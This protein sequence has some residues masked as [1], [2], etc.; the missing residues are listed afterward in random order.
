M[1]IYRITV[2]KESN[3]EVVATWITDEYIENITN[4]ITQGLA[5]YDTIAE[6]Y[7]ACDPDEDLE[8]EVDLEDSIDDRYDRG[9]S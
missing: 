1:E 6:Y 8:M 5:T 9:E 4:A 7:E 2:E 3:N